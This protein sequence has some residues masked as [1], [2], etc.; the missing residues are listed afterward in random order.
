MVDTTYYKKPEETID[1]YN[2]RIGMSKNTVADQD[3]YFQ[4]LANV[5]PQAADSAM[6]IA[7]Y[8]G[9]IS[10]SA[11]T[12][13]PTPQFQTPKYS[14]VYPVASLGQMQGSFDMT[15]EE[16]RAQTTSD[17][18][19]ALNTQMVGQSQFRAEQ[20]QAQNI[21]GLTQTQNDLTSRLT[22]LKNEAL[23][24]PLQMQQDALGRG[25]TAGGLRP[26]ETGALRNNAIQA[27]SVNS[28]LEA[29]RGNLTMAL[30]MVERAVAQKYDPIREEIAAKTAN[31]DLILKSPA[32][33]LAD[34]KRAEQQRLIQEQASQ[35]LAFEQE[36]F[37]TIQ[38]MA[39]DAAAQGA[40]SLTLTKIQQAANAAEAAQI[41]APYLK[42]KEESWGDPFLLGGDYV[43]RN[44]VTGEIRTAVNVAAGSGGSTAGQ[45]VFDSSG[46]ALEFGTPEY[47]VARLQSTAG[48]KTKLTQSEREQIGKFANV[49]SLTENLMGSL[50]KTNSDPIV[51]YMKSLNPYDF[52]ARA[53]NAQVT[54]LVPSVA[55]ALYGEVGVLTDQDIARY[56]KTLPN[57]RSTED[58]NKF[59]ATMTLANAKRSYEQTLL[60]AASSGVNV[61]G[62]VDSY[63]NMSA[64][65]D[66]LEREIG[67]GQTETVAFD[68]SELSGL[69]FADNSPT[70]ALDS[71]VRSFFWGL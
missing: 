41:A 37:K 23:A 38:Q 40:D 45:P 55:R 53:V 16:Q 39:I 52:D 3:A 61:S 19:Q 48:S 18:L 58:Q 13:Q 33:S 62:F 47:I 32:Y 56:L 29:S 66:R 28:L 5:N 59:I 42:A 21:Q 67:A 50:S 71:G 7:G 68:E 26:L 20:E 35:N 10:S 2:A 4:S 11:L 49:V 24:I 31:L 17:E 12:P 36:Q 30:D 6:N 15:P 43:Q 14:P 9:A 70:G 22:A 34:K 1:Q 57:I 60:N 46:N 44:N 69:Q 63:R 54:A 8:G 25:I 65:L 27:L 64:T 51:G